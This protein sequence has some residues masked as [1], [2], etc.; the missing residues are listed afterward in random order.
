MSRKIHIVLESRIPR[1][2]IAFDGK[3]CRLIQVIWNDI[4]CLRCVGGL[5]NRPDLRVCPL[6]IFHAIVLKVLSISSSEYWNIAPN[7]CT[8]VRNQN[9]ANQV[10][11]VRQKASSPDRGT[12]FGGNLN[13]R[14]IRTSN[15]VLTSAT[16][17]T[18]E[19]IM[20]KI[21][22]SVFPD[23]TNLSQCCVDEKKEEHC[24]HESGD[25]KGLHGISHF[26]IWP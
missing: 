25:L 22:F 5:K 6:S 16:Q 14:R 9:L 2:K 24:E 17:T 19:A 10:M 1:G 26:R 21:R 12:T 3:I 23:Y 15:I 20:L 8:V 11:G 13:K 18:W 4:M 7:Q